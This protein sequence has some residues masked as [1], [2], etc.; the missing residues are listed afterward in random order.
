MAR[1]WGICLWLA[2]A[3]AT[4]AN[5]VPQ[6]SLPDTAGRVHTPAEWSGKRAVVLFFLTTDCPLCNNYVPELNRVAGAFSA[7]GVAFYGVQGDATISDAD[8]RRHVQDY[9]YTFPYLF[10]PNE[11]L[12]AAT[13]ATATPEAAVLS[14]SGELLYLGRI[15]N[16][17]EDFGKQRVQVT[18]YD[19]RD[20][21]EAILARK[22]VPHAR[23]KALGCA[24]TRKD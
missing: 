16:R 14:P 7:R 2:L 17:L 23:T 8:V 15:D 11:S 9:A 10:D 1:N 22:P 5:R 12:A 19:L 20:T 3:C 6:F 21:L 4:A 24:I 18:E 13:G